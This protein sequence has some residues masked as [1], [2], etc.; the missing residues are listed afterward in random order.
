MISAPARSPV[1]RTMRLRPVGGFAAE[2][3]V[4]LR[5][6]VEGHAETERGRR[7]GRRLRMR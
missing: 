1:T 6:A 5:V 4:A 3:E 2:D 7:C